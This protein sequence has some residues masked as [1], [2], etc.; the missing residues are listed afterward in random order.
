[1]SLQ[2]GAALLFRGHV[3]RQSLGF[4]FFQITTHQELPPGAVRQAS[5]QGQ[6][7]AR[8]KVPELVGAY[9]VDSGEVSLDGGQVVAVPVEQVD[10]FGDYLL[11][12]PSGP[13]V[14]FTVKSSASPKSMRVSVTKRSKST[15]V[16][17]G[18]D[19]ICLTVSRPIAIPSRA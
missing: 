18:S 2:P 9:P 11:R 3:L 13:P 7:F 16:M 12:G 5:P 14:G 6:K 4:A 1:M 8:V 15:N 19:A 17:V 10:E